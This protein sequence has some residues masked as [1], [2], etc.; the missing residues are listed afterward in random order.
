MKHENNL[1]LSPIAVYGFRDREKTLKIPRPYTCF[2]IDDYGLFLRSNHAYIKG[3][4][5]VK[6]F[7]LYPGMDLIK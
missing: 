3:I 4:S 7:K 2:M 1:A 6:R 5:N